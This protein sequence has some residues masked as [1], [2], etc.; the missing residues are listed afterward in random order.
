VTQVPLEAP[1]LLRP[2][3]ELARHFREIH[4]PTVRARAALL[5]CSGDEALHA[6]IPGPPVVVVGALVLSPCSPR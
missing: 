3:I 1:G 2:F 4:W 5:A 6:R